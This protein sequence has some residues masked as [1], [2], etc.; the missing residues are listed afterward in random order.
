MKRYKTLIPPV[1]LISIYIGTL[2]LTRKFFPTSAEL[3]SQVATFY[4][5]FGYEIIFLASM[6]EALFIV[7]L[8]APGAVAV[9][10]GAVFARSGQLDLTVGIILAV[11]GAM[12]GYIL[13]YLIG[14]FGFS[15][16]VEGLG[17]REYTRRATIEL[18][19]SYFKSFSL[20]FIHPN[21]GAVVS[22]A[23]GILKMNFLRFILL[24]ALSTLIWYSL[25]GILGFALGEVF[26]TLLTKYA[27]IIMLLVAS[28][29]ILTYLY[30]KWTKKA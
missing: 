16:V 30:G 25:W 9:G 11:A 21:I 10:L 20:G 4:G 22:T 6:I 23:A 29:W 28:I 18:K 7:N 24:A 26:L 15:K 17:F 1:T 19:A 8:F 2:L 27:F 3:V 14:F 13:D 12:L 5:S